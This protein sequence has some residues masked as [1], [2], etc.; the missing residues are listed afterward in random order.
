MALQQELEEVKK[1]LLKEITGSI[2]PEEKI[3]LQ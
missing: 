1:Y 2:T 3:K